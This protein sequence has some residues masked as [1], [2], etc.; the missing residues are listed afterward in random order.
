MIT[1]EQ[2]NLVR[3][4]CLDASEIWLNKRGGLWWWEPNMRGIT[5]VTIKSW[6]ITEI[7]DKHPSEIITNIPK[8]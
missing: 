5:V 2:N 8:Y 6:K 4:Y 3:C 1:L 7:D